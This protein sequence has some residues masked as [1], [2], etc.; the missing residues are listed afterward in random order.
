MD[1]KIGIVEPTDFSNDAI[2]LLKSIGEVTCFDMQR[3]DAASFL[4]DKHCIFVRLKH[5]FG[6]ELLTEAK[7]L[8]YIC[9]PT[10]GLNH[11][12]LDYARKANIKILSLKGEVGFLNGITATPE[13]TFGLA[14]ALLRNYNRA[15][16][17]AS[18]TE[19]D[20]D[21]YKGFELKGINAGIIGLGRVGNILCRYLR[22]F[23]ANVYY[24]DI[25]ENAN[26]ANRAT[27]KNSIEQLISTSQLIFLCV[28][29]SAQ[30][31]RMLSKKY[32]DMMKN[33]FFVNTSRGELIDEEYMIEC[34]K[35]NHFAGAAIDVI[36]NETGSNNAKQFAM[37][38]E[39]HNLIVTPHI[40]GATYN[41]M[42]ETEAFI[43]K[44]LIEE[45]T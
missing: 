32:L 40:A 29:Y 10:T 7:D 22:A 19:W 25:E 13:H 31:N 14:L 9:T 21:L 37:L 35:R 11:I 45:L 3:E 30:N 41:S 38:A 26:N 24:Y 6:K 33:K 4:R 8:K 42:W 18:N 23:G 28:S 1:I 44:K 2:A 39:D 20:R 43:A 27:Q 36:A 16:L 5:Y 17:N 34:I 15:F 12:D